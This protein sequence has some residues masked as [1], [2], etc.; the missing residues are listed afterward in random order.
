MR[1]ESYSGI[2][3]SAPPPKPGTERFVHEVAELAW[4]NGLTANSIAARLGGPG[5]IMQVKRALAK[6]VREGI[7]VLK[8]PITDEYAARLREQTRF[9]AVDYT[10]VRTDHFHELQA[11]CAVTS[12][13]IGDKITALVKERPAPSE[14]II[15]NAGGRA[16]S[17]AV[18]LLHK[19]PPLIG[20]YDGKRLT[21]LALNSAGRRRN[22]DQSSNFLAVR[23]AEIFGGHHIAILDHTDPTVERE[24][25]GKVKNIDLLLCGAGGLDS[26]LIEHAREQQVPVPDHVVGDFAFIPL[27]S[28]GRTVETPG[29]H[30]VLAKLSPHPDYSEILRIA[31]DPTKAV[32]VVFSEHG[33]KLEIAQ[34]VLTAGLVTH[35]VLSLSLANRLIDF[36]GQ[37]SGKRRESAVTGRRKRGTPKT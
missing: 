4:R 26:L 20:P 18:R 9:K 6:A 3:A 7:L 13:L 14:I 33:S 32:L 25:A 12:E 31:R 17:E 21:F 27:D 35:C 29:L 30:K 34:A 15:A 23:L 24:Y 2:S 11:I 1:D 16:L 37:H 19:N 8:P 10:V 5:M 36:L 28:D 22:F